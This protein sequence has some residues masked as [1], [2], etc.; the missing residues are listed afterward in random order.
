MISSALLLIACEKKG[1]EEQHRI[2]FEHYAI[3]YAWG[4]SYVHWVIDDEG[5][6]RTNHKKESDVI[7]NSNN[8]NSATIVFDSI[9]YKIDKN[10][11]DHHT[12]LILFAAKGQ[13][14][15]TIQTRAD[16][17][18]TVFNCFWYKEKTNIYA[19][20]ILSQMSDKLDKINVDSNAVKIDK[21]LKE[22]HSKIYSN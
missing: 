7:L 3:N 19:T 6:V 11:L 5:N 16:F 15:S 14:D 13:I 4:F 2:Y 17:G 21:W 9:I 8:I 22:I 18:N 20:I 10:E 12:S 1:N